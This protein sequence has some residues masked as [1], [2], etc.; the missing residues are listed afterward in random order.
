MSRLSCS[1]GWDLLRRGV[2]EPLAQS[3]DL[4]EDRPRL[5]AGERDSQAL[6]PETHCWILHRMA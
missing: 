5:V 4:T 1:V 3:G 2:A 6:I